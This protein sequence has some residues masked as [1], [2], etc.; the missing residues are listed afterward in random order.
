MS[1]DTHYKVLLLDDEKFL[2]EIYSIKFHRRGFDVFACASADDAIVALTNGY[3]PD[4][5]LFDIT[6]PGKSGY[7]FIEE[8]TRLHL[9]RHALKVALTNESQPG[10]M[11]RTKELGAVAH[12]IKA[13]YTPNEI[14]DIVSNLLENR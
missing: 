10:E 12:L 1:T 14:V 9:G 6:M 8:I 4:A 3:E 5:I 11:E 13:E 2:L 7:E